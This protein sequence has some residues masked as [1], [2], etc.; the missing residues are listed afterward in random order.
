VRDDLLQPLLPLG[1]DVP[2]VLSLAVSPDQRKIAL[3][4]GSTIIL[5]RFA[6][7]EKGSQHG[8]VIERASIRAVCSEKNSRAHQLSFT[9]DSSRLISAVQV[10]GNGIPHQHQ[11]HTEVWKCARALELESPLGSVT[12]VVVSTFH[13]RSNDAHLLYKALPNP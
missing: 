7:R 6:E 1:E 10:P 13:S 5:I 2:R 9:P 3:G 11:V 8:Y 4:C 12:I